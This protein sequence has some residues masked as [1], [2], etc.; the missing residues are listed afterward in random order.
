[1]PLEHDGRA[2]V[3]VDDGAEVWTERPRCGSAMGKVRAA[4]ATTDGALAAA[5]GEQQ[6]LLP[7]ALEPDH[8]AL[9][10]GEAYPVQLLEP[11]RR[12]PAAREP[13][14]LGALQTRS[15]IAQVRGAGPLAA[16]QVG[17]QRA[18]PKVCLS[19]PAAANLWSR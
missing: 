12:T 18:N 16:V 1:V 5:L 8:P 11:Q 14:V 2:V 13:A 17:Q 15:A 9:G 3:G 6:V 4:E 19:V 7:A 10:I